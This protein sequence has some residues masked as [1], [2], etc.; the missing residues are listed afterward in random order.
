MDVDFFGL[1]GAIRPVLRPFPT[2]PAPQIL[3]DGTMKAPPKEQGWLAKYWMYI[4]PV[5]VMLLIG[6]GGAPEEEGPA[7]G[8]PQAT[9]S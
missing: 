2:G 3:P 8:A 6:G 1:D 5:V 7:G 9:K 4:L